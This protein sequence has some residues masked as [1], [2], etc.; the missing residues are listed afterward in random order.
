MGLNNKKNSD[1]IRYTADPLSI[2]VALGYLNPESLTPDDEAAGELPQDFDDVESLYKKISSGIDEAVIFRRR[3][4]PNGEIEVVRKDE[5]PR[6][7]DLESQIGGV[8]RRA[9]PH[10]ATGENRTAGAPPNLGNLVVM[11]DR[12]EWGYGKMID[13]YTKMGRT[14][15]TISWKNRPP[16]HVSSVSIDIPF[17]LV[18]KASVWL[19][20]DSIEPMPGVQVI[21]RTFKTQYFK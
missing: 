14:Y 17:D 3:M 1:N 15:C 10:S 12:L 9:N 4:L 5:K 2:A 21:H 11:I 6:S 8:K 18:G 16:N 20:P 7:F 19:D 13:I